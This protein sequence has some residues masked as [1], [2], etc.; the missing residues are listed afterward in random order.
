MTADRPRETV[1]V[2]ADWLEAEAFRT[3]RQIT[4]HPRLGIA[5][6]HG[7]HFRFVAPL[8]VSAA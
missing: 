5:E 1:E 2:D 6:L 7:D 8:G 3:G 4:I